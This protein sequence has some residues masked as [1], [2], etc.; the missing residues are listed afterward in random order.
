MKK[1]RA[2]DKLAIPAPDYNTMVDAAQ[3]YL[4]RQRDQ[5]CTPGGRF[6]DAGIIEIKNGSGADRERFDVL[7]IDEPIF[8]L[9][10]AAGAEQP[11]AVGVKPGGPSGKIAVLLEPVA[12]GEVARAC[13]SG[14]TIARIDLVD[15]SHKWAELKE[16]E[17]GHLQTRRETGAGFILWSSDETGT[18][19]V[20]LR[21]SNPPSETYI[22]CTC[23]MKGTG[24]SGSKG[25]CTADNVKI[26]MGTS[27]LD[28]PDDA[29]E[30]LTV[31]NKH[32]YDFDDNGAA[33]IEWNATR[34]CWEIYQIDCPE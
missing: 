11:R 1:F 10:T 26:I 14:M 12:D 8:D 27:P 28:D 22:R 29:A 32:G 23:L 16:N 13:V 3:E 6:L 34:V 2:G 20:L 25:D 7:E 5:G 33:D 21:L 24:G 30:E 9:D 18:Q 31:L 15:A 19:L 4:G 17:C